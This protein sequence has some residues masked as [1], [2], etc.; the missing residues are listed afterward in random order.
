MKL[1]KIYNEWK[2]YTNQL[3]EKTVYPEYKDI[4]SGDDLGHIQ[5]IS[6]FNKGF[7]L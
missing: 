7:G 6:K 5:L 4:I 1:N 2:N 3:L